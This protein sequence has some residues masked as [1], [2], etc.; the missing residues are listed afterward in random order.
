MLCDAIV[1]FKGTVDRLDVAG[2]GIAYIGYGPMS[3]GDVNNQPTY[4]T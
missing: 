1:R 2:S 4:F 3:G